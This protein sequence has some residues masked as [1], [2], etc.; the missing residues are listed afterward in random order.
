MEID[1]LTKLVINS[2]YEVARELGYGFSETVY[3]NSLVI[4]LKNKGLHLQV[5]EKIKVYYKGAFA[6]DFIPDVVVNGVLMLEIKRVAALI[7]AHEAQLVNYL[8]ITGIND[9]LLINFADD[10]V[11]IRRKFR[12][13]KKPPALKNQ[14]CKSLRIL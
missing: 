13:R 4:E 3:E 11:E 8:Q 5:Q 9:G 10:K 14:A 7:P 6:G 12:I 1:D 2:S